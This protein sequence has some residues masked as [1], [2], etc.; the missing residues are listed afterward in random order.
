MLLPY[1]SESEQRRI[2]TFLDNKCSEIDQLISLQEQFIEELKAYKQSVITEAVT[3]G[4]NPEVEMKESGV[5]WIGRIPKEW[6]VCQL[7][8]NS[9]VMNGKEITK[10]T[11][12]INAI[13]VF[14]SGGVFK[15]NENFIADCET[16]MF[17]RKGTLGKPIY[18]KGK[19]WVVDTMYYLT[20]NNNVAPKYI[21]YQL[22]SFDWQPYITQTALPSIV[23]STI[24][25]C[26]FAFPPIQ[27]QRAIATYLDTKCAEIDSL[28]ALKQ[29]KIDALKDYKK[30]IIYEYVTGKKT[31]S[32]A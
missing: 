32:N 28:I 29:Q 19:F 31:V 12:D 20:F 1:F 10:E 15:Y 13:P 30:S 25:N 17:G 16:V 2:A 11:T 8:R 3:K 24:G 5:E 21:Y 23:G 6:K 18:F 14:G 22:T 9:Q 4:L 7:K 27:E 26:F